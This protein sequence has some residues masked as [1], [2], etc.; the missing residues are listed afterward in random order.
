MTTPK[1]DT[2]LL[3]EANDKLT[4]AIEA[5]RHL[6]DSVKEYKSHLLG[7]F[8]RT[9]DARTLLQRSPEWAAMQRELKR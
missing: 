6:T 3:I 2:D 5:L 4:D 9:I 1:S 7:S 8:A